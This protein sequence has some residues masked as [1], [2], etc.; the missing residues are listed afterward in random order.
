M[1]KF[2]WYK[3]DSQNFI[4]ITF[5][6]FTRVMWKTY[7]DVAPVH[8]AAWVRRLRVRCLARCLGTSPPVSVARSVPRSGSVPRSAARW[9]A[10]AD[11]RSPQRRRR[12]VSR[13]RGRRAE[14]RLRGEPPQRRVRLDRRRDRALRR[15]RPTLRFAAARRDLPPHA[16]SRR[17]VR[18]RRAPRQVLRRAHQL[19]PP[20]ERPRRAAA[21]PPPPRARCRCCGER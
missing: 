3:N 19:L 20:R 1:T 16:R 2:V 4:R 14:R 8:S 15:Q 11:G 17:R 13:V 12:S 6:N 9:S 10:A 5:Q 21:R 18:R 7:F